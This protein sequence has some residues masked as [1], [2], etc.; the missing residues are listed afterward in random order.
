MGEQTWHVEQRFA[1]PDDEAIYGLGQFHEGVMNFK[2]Y[3]LRLRQFNTVIALPFYIS[4][5]GYGLFWNNASMTEWNPERE[6]LEHHIQASWDYHWTLYEPE[7]TGEYTFIL[8]G[9]KEN[10]SVYM[11]IDELQMVNGF[12]ERIPQ[13][14]ICQDYDVI[15]QTLAG[16]VHLEKG[17]HYELNYKANFEHLYVRTPRMSGKSTLRS[18][19]ADAIDYYVMLGNADHAIAQLRELTGQAPM[20]PRWAYGFTQSRYTYDTEVAMLGAARGYRDRHYPI[21][22]VVQDMN[23][24]EATEQRNTWGSHLYDPKKF[25]DPEGMYRQLHND[26]NVHTLISVWPRIHRDADLF[27][28][29]VDKGYSLG[30]QNTS[31]KSLEGFTIVGEQDNVAIDPYNP[32][33]RRAYWHFMKERLWDKGVDGWWLDASEPEWGYDFRQ[34]QTYVGSGAR[35]LNTYSLMQT[36]AIYDGQRAATA[37][38]RVVILTRSAFPGQQRYATQCWSGDIGIT[39]NTMRQQIAA[40]LN[41]SMAGMPYWSCDVGG[42]RPYMKT[43]SHSYL[44]LVTRWLQWGTFLPIMRVHGCRSTELWDLGPEAEQI[45]VAYDRFRYRLLPYI[46]SIADRVS[47]EG[48]TILRGLA[49]D[50]PSDTMTWRINDQF[51]MGPALMVCPVTEYKARSREVYLPKGRQW[52]DFWTDRLTDGEHTMHAD[53]PIGQT[54]VFVPAGTILPLGEVMEYATERPSDIIDLRIYPGADADFTLYEDENDNYN[55]EQGQCTRIPFHWDDQHRRLTIGAAR[56]SFPGMLRQ[57]TFRVAIVN[58]GHHTGMDS[59]ATYETEITYTN[60]RMSITL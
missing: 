10:A 19:V 54:P 7:E 18:E 39:W 35:H 5:R 34:S 56:G 22:V 50:A 24:W 4:T 32:E 58:E 23:Y 31:G 49:M 42:F 15:P 30:I 2:D 59:S 1:S 8:D 52:Y 3:Y 48:Y 53:A 25:P 37:E 46:Y 21:D 20:F 55:Y 16:R 9:L 33:A 40:G 29:F 36:S 13:T 47:Q 26:Y 27:Q 60:K 17:R 41:Y 12:E 57:R 45:M 44:E 38:K 51:M 6:E 14:V 11:T 43:H 28:Y